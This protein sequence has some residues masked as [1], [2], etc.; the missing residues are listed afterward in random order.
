MS[1]TLENGQWY[2]FRLEGREFFARVYNDMLTGFLELTEIPDPYI[3]K[4]CGQGYLEGAHDWFGAPGTHEYEKR[5]DI[6]TV[7]VTGKAAARG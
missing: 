1:V 3:C 5:G 6:G 4:V 7:V 2:A